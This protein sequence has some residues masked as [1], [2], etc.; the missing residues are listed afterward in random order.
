MR[1]KS[2]STILLTLS[3]L[4]S[5]VIGQQVTGEQREIKSSVVDKNNITSI[6]YNYGSIGK[7]NTLGNIADLVWNGLGTM[8]EFGPLISA[9]VIGENGET[10]HITSD[11][12][13]LSMQG[14]YNSD[15]TQKWGWLPRAGYADPTQNEIARSSI[16]DSDGDG[17]PDSWPESWYS[18]SEG[19]YLWPGEF[20]DG[21]TIAEE[22]VYY[23]MDDFSNAEFPYYPFPSDTTKRG[24]GVK[25]DVR[26]YQFG[27]IL[28]DAL[29]IKY[30]ITNESPKDLSKVYFGFHGDP[31][32]GGPSDYGDD[33][34]GFV[35]AN[36]N[37]NTLSNLPEELY[38]TIYNWDDDGIGGGGLPTGYF[39]LKLLETPN[40]LGLTSFHVA[41]YT[42]SDPNVP[43]NDALMWQWLSA[44]SIDYNQEL[45]TQSSDNIINF[46]TG[47]FELK[48]GES[49]EVKLALVFSY[50]VDDMINDI[51][52]VKHYS[53]WP[54]ISSAYNSSGGND[55]Y[56]IELNELA[57]ENDGNV[58]ISWN[59]SGTDPNAEVFI[60]YSRDS[61]LNW[62]PLIM[63]QNINSNFSW[64]TKL[65]DDGMNYILRVLAYNPE[66][67]YEHYHDNS[68]VRFTINNPEVNAVPE[69][70]FL[71]PHNQLKD[72]QVKVEWLSE[73]ADNSE[74]LITVEYAQ[75]RDVLTGEKI[76]EATLSNGLNSFYW[77]ISSIPNS[78]GNFLIFKCKDNAN[79][80][81]YKAGPFTI[82]I[83][84]GSYSESQIEHISGKGSVDIEVLVAD[85][86][87]L[88]GDSYEIKF[89]IDDNKTKYNITNVNR[90]VLLLE[91]FIGNTTPTFEGLRLKITEMEPGI[92]YEKTHFNREELGSTY[93]VFYSTSNLDYI[94]QPHVHTDLDWIVVFND[95]DTLSDGS[96]AN[97]GDNSILVVPSMSTG[98][99]A[100]FKIID[101]DNNEKANYILDESR[102]PNLANNSWDKGEFIVLRPQNP[103]GA[104]EVS[105]ALDFDF[106]GIEP[107]A[108]D[109]LYIVTNNPIDNDDIFKFTA[110]NDYV[111]LNKD[112]TIIPN[113]IV[114]YQNYPNPFNPSTIISYSL[115]QSDF[116]KVMV[117]DVLG[118]EVAILVNK[119]QSSGN[120]KINFNATNLSSGIYFYKIVSGNYS[121][122]K[123]MILLR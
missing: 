113:E 1:N 120:Y 61:G 71:N 28:E 33:R 32:I 93:N 58:D 69:F 117:Y 63:G 99:V 78:Y 106:T 52:N 56:K 94:G 123:K 114:L 17:K 37:S 54:E 96:W 65:V 95:L 41:P 29:I 44:D 16:G 4:S 12:Y 14:D 70:R 45:L 6:L 91:N 105:Y 75:N 3:L 66:N 26:I 46:G 22:E 85:T 84:A 73:D 9:E 39:S 102:N 8:F 50:D 119:E 72:Q 20:G 122:I 110:N 108:G 2:L 18:S 104:A 36:G 88:T 98:G 40:N 51:I 97:I 21:V 92:D 10:L 111:L 101:I 87:M 60:D 67:K 115:H 57:N 76:Y 15:G 90:D 49:K 81:I 121:D 25:V 42:N 103:P 83:N 5:I 38:S 116:V 27:G 100:P 48:A 74:L 7:P 23:V 112:K 19:R 80:T 55:N 79:E 53:Y 62:V 43:R 82:D 68:N 77:D 86:T 13:I 24:L 59:Y 35:D 64:D 31:H 11:S 118:R 34:V 30:I 109:T 47:A 89:S 107:Q